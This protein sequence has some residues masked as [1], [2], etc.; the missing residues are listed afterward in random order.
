MQIS[1][2]FDSGNIVVK[3]IANPKKIELQIR[4][5]HGSHFFQ[6]FHYRLTGAKDTHCV[7]HITNAHK[8]AYPKGWYN[9][10]ACASYD[11]KNWFRVS[12]SYDGKTLIIRHRPSMNSIYF[13]YFAPYS[14]ERHADLISELQGKKFVELKVL[15]QT[16]DGQDLELL[17][18]DGP[19]RGKKRKKPSIWI[20]A[21]QH[22]GETM[23]SWWME[24]FLERLTD[25]MDPVTFKLRTLVNFYII[26]NM[27]PD[28]S[29]RGHLRTNAIGVNLNREWG[30]SSMKNSPEVHLTIKAMNR[31][32]LDFHLDVHGDEEIPYNF[33]MGFE[34][35]K[36]ASTHLVNQADR[37]AK[38]I[39]NLSPD[40]QTK[41]GYPK[42][43]QGTADMT[44]ASNFI[45]HTFKK[46]SVTLEMPFKDTKT[47]PCL[48]IGWSPER[49][50]RLGRAFV[51]GFYGV[52]KTLSNGSQKT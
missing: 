39:E 19:K 14:M 46:V 43:K 13:A 26:P 27:N 21:R 33:L 24:G 31:F 7:M 1:S 44:I 3:S 12:T 4:R 22:P 52:A 8:S 49:C 29:K 37:F 9:Y 17:K 51:D 36:N 10:M 35:I 47:N 2:N 50:K 20:T 25:F 32:G 6:W 18:F 11:R 15:G 34:G 23:A 30:V 28:G 48:R 5:D 41:Y 42:F 16:L 38:E 40:F 45:A